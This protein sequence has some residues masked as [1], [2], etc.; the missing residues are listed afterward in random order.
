M[1]AILIIFLSFPQSKGNACVSFPEEILDLQHSCILVSEVQNIA[2][3]L[4]PPCSLSSGV[5]KYKNFGIIFNGR[6]FIDFQIDKQLQPLY[7]GFKTGYGRGKYLRLGYGAAFLPVKYFSMGMSF[8]FSYSFDSENYLF[9]F[10]GGISG[11]IGSV[12]FFGEVSWLKEF[13]NFGVHTGAVL[14]PLPEKP[15]K[16]LSGL[17]IKGKRIYP[18][19]GFEYSLGALEFFSGFG[20][21]RFFAGLNVDYKERIK[22]KEV[23]K[24]VEVVKEVPVYIEKEKKKEKEPVVSKPE[25]KE[26]TEEEKRMLEFHYKKG[27]EYY[28]KDLLEEALREW[29]KVS[30]IDPEYKDVKKYIEETQKKLQKLKEIK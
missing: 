21:N 16:L 28:K 25:K 20:D 24:K 10:Q 18:S 9:D 26:L 12:R 19:I 3:L 13:E 30:E 14:K 15:L 23:V 27:I 11:G 22:V 6:N 29:E 7:L 8:L 5:F 2:F 4:S 1:R 17:M